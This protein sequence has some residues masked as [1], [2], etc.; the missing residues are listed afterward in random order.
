MCW[1]DIAFFVIIFFKRHTN[2][3]GYGSIHN[4]KC[5]CVCVCVCVCALPNLKWSI[6]KK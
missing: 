2:L 1:Y 5:V 3:S 6:F 4:D